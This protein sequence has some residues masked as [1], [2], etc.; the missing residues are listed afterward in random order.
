[1]VRRLTAVVALALGVIAVGGTRPAAAD[2]NHANR[3]FLLGDSTLAALRWTGTAPLLAPYDYLL[4]A[5]SCRRITGQSCRGREGYAPNNGIEAMTSHNGELGDTVVAMIGYDDAGAIFGAEV[6]ALIAEAKR[7]GVKRVIWLTFKTD[8]SYVGPTYASD[9]T[10]YKSNNRILTEKATQYSGY[11]TLA[12]WNT[13]GHQHPDWFA[14]D[15]IHLSLAGGTGLANYVHSVLDQRVGSR[16]SD[17]SPSRGEVT[18]GAAVAGDTAPAGIVLSAPRRLVDTRDG[19]PIGTSTALRIP[20]SGVVPADTT[21]VI[22]NITGTDPCAAGF[23]AAYGC[24]HTAPTTSN[25]NLEIGTDRAT[26]AIVPVAGE[27]LCVLAQQRTDV[28][29]DL[30]GYTTA[31]S[32]ARL[33]PTPPRRLLDT[34]DG[35]GADTQKGALKPG[36][37]MTVSAAKVSGRPANATG[38]AVNATAVGSS[39]AG[40][41]AVFP[42]GQEPTTSVTNFE[43]R[44]VVAN[45]TIV[46]LGSDASLCVRSNVAVDVVL[47]VNGWVTPA[48]NQHV[49]KAPTRL[50]DTRVNKGGSRLSAGGVLRVP[51]AAASAASG[52]VLS[53]TSVDGSAGNFLTVYPCDQTVP[54]ASNLNTTSAET[55]ANLV[56]AALASSGETCV[57]ARRATDVVV[58]LF[59]VLRAATT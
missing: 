23:L 20:L 56:I 34:R 37:T 26:S 13:V 28:I 16:C 55:R 10:T 18:V 50:V 53:V 17:T 52:A 6:D 57:F 27:D 22:V 40:W 29:V 48:G 8:V 14:D 31:S 38:V 36:T 11:V 33:A 2:Y 42:C 44:E 43:G 19:N 41:L 45:T 7:Q 46:G 12:D 24:G 5:E 59:G 54:V 9:D 30:F 47:D 4:D 51:V 32:T 1:M 49:A 35:S 3:V 21:S 58:D 39:E 15:G 25:V